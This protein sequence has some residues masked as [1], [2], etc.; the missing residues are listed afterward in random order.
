MHILSQAAKIG[1]Q[2]QQRVYLVGGTV[3]DLLLFR[4]KV[5]LDLAVEGNG[6]VLARQLAHQLG[7]RLIVHER[8]LTAT[9]Y[10]A[11]ERIDI[12]TCRQESYPQP[13]ALPEIKPANLML[14]LARRDFS[15]NAMAI[16]LIEGNKE[17]IIDPYNGRRDLTK[18]LLRVLHSLSFS[19]DPLRILR[20]VRLAA[21]LKFKFEAQ[22]EGLIRQ[23]LSAGLLDK[24]EERRFWREFA[25]L[26]RE[27]QPAVAWGKLSELGWRGFAGY[28]MPDIDAGR[29]AEKL[30]CQWQSKVYQELDTALVYFLIATV[31][32]NLTVIEN[33]LDF[34]NWERKRRFKVEKS[35]KLWGE[36]ALISSNR[37]RRS[38]LEKW[39]PAVETVIFILAM[40]GEI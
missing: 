4:S 30:I 28:G 7:G 31:K 16:P 33:I 22:T 35:R 14:D 11:A 26:F 40:S 21:R 17:G 36:L 8:F 9:V 27:Q 6:L 34:L 25:L 38:L 1:V 12:A 39:E 5:D 29:R 32:L 13:G 24:L 2:K 19:D 15:I 18:G 23:A 20:G 10:W 37:L 3:R